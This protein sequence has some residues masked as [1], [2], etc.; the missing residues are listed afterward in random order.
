MN[1][2]EVKR[3]QLQ[4]C[5]HCLGLVVLSILAGRIYYNGVTYLA[6]AIAFVAAMGILI[7]GSAADTLGRLLRGRNAKGQ[8]KNAAKLRRSIFYVQLVLGLLGSSILLLLANPVA[9]SVLKIPYS[10]YLIMLIAPIIFLRTMSAVFLGCLQ[11]EGNELF[12]AVV[13]IVRYL[14]ILLLGLLFSGRLLEYG[15]K[16]S[17][18]LGKGTFTAMYGGMGIAVA[19]VVS[20]LIVGVLLFLGYKTIG[21]KK[22]KKDAE[23]MKAT[24]SFGSQIKLFQGSRGVLMLSGLTTFLPFL[25]GFIFFQHYIQNLCMA[26]SFTLNQGEGYQDMFGIYLAK[27]MLPCGLVIL[28]LLTSILPLIAKL[29]SSIRKEEQRFARVVF[30]GGMKN[31]IVFSLF[32]AVYV[33]VMAEQLA[34]VFSPNAIETTTETVLLADM[35]KGGSFIIVLLPLCYY[36]NRVLILSGKRYAVLACGAI[37]DVI[38][39]I[40]LLIMYQ[41]TLLGIMALVYGGLLFLLVYMLLL[42]A[43]LLR[44]LQAGIDYLRVLAIPVGSACVAGLLS[45]LL[46]KICTPH[47]GNLVTVLVCFVLSLMVYLV[48]VLF[49]RCYNEQE[50]SMLPGGR[51]LKAAGQ[52]IRVFH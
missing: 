5:S 20:E 30:Q 47:L 43:L 28:L 9:E 1:Q 11:G 16:V 15:Q 24:D 45:F 46:A 21:K 29:S 19:I 4:L 44:Q 37:A 32:W 52:L 13:N 14:L 17:N 12:S 6:G 34:G 7:N 8:Y 41:K 36:F 18:L 25:T 51:V 35:L 48:L 39:I 27:Y 33:M 31:L 40:A 2:V 42:C 26:N 22:R 38:S 3:K 23:G 49:F 50:L 10:K